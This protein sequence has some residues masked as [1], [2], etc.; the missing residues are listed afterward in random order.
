MSYQSEEQS[1]SNGSPQEL[2]EINYSTVIYNYTSG[3]SQYTNPSNGKVYKPL[4]IRRPNLVFSSDNGRS[5]L[6]LNVQPNADFLELFRY[7]PPPSVVSLTIKRLQRNDTAHEVVTVWK[8]RI[9][10]AS[11]DDVE[12]TITCESIRSSTLR[13]GLRKMFTIQCQHVLY[14]VDCLA[15]RAAFELVGVITAIS[16]STLNMSGVA[17]KPDGWFAGGYCEWTDPITHVTNR[18]M[19]T[20]SFLGSDTLTLVSPPLG[21]VVGIDIHSMPGCDHTMAMCEAKFANSINYGGMIHTPTKS[22]FNGE[23]LY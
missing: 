1:I 23:L 20:A 9:L 11:W 12:A 15:N 13:F 10:N 22:P 3:D 17:V 14:G 16:G 19:I 6:Q 18:R 4:V 8:G 21:A 5:S 7:A 2:Y